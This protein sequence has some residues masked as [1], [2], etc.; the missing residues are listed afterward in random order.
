LT[1]RRTPTASK[2]PAI[3][4]CYAELALARLVNIE[5]K[6]LGSG[7][8]LNITHKPSRGGHDRIVVKAL[9]G[10][11]SARYQKL[12]L[13]IDYEKEAAARH[14]TEQIC[15]GEKKEAYKEGKVAII[16]CYSK[17]KIK[18]RMLKIY[19]VVW[20][21]RSEEVL[22]TIANLPRDPKERKKI[23]NDSKYVE[24]LLKDT[25]VPRRVAER[26]SELLESENQAPEAS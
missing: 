5:L 3:A 14:Y 8:Y 2:L 19:A 23:K 10:A 20:E 15:R 4:E 6:E 21:P 13:F 17:R 25:G 22:E 18:N 12:V 7:Y 16:L 1:Q 9:R 11:A 26:L 24:R